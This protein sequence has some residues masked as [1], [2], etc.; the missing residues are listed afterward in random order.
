MK[1]QGHQDCLAEELKRLQTYTG[2]FVD[3]IYK[4]HPSSKNVQSYQYIKFRH[5]NMGWA[6]LADF[7]GKEGTEQF[8]RSYCLP[9]R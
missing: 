9:Y 4:A 1:Y 5:V 2:I 8:H 3:K 7:E 6:R